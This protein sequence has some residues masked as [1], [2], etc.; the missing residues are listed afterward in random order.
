ML[1]HQPVGSGSL[2]ASHHTS[3]QSDGGLTPSPSRWQLS[4]GTGTMGGGTTPSFT[5]SL[6]GLAK[7]LVYGG[8]GGTLEEERKRVWNMKDLPVLETGKSLIGV[9]IKLKEGEEA[10]CKYT[11]AGRSG[12]RVTDANTGH[13]R[14]HHAAAD[15]PAAF[16]QGQGLSILIRLR[17]IPNCLASRRRETA[18]G[19]GHTYPHPG[20]VKRHWYVRSISYVFPS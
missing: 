18:K 17:R 1:L 14:I 4:F 3:A 9:D 16:A 20:M 8:Q 12:R 10:E 11:A 2:S 13:S 6:F 19:E 15:G 7:D 5:G